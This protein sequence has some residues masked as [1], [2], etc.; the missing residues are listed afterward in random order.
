MGW[1][2]S[3]PKRPPLLLVAA[4]GFVLGWFVL[5]LVTNRTQIYLGSDFDM[6]TS[7]SNDIERPDTGNE[8]IY[9][10]GTVLSAKRHD[11]YFWMRRYLA[12]IVVRPIPSAIW[13]TK[14]ADFGVP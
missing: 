2:F 5:F 10:S 6:K 4:G 7:V 11:H 1:Y 8:Y 13:P 14:Y 3:R 12:Q 9:G